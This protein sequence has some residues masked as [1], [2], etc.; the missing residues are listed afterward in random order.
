MCRNRTPEPAREV[1]GQDARGPRSRG[2]VFFGYFLLHKQK[3][4][5]R[6]PGWR[7]K[8]HKDVIAKRPNP[9]RRAKAN[10]IPAFAGMT[11]VW[12][13]AFA[14][15]TKWDSASRPGEGSE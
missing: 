8:Q 10:W 12:I 2:C 9:K 3:K 11:E 4:V 1:R 13:P 15:M 6:P 7:T 5:T 14:A